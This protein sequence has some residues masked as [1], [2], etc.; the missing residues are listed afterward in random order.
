MILTTPAAQR[1]QWEA[2]REAVADEYF[3]G[4]AAAA[5]RVMDALPYSDIPG[6][7]DVR[8]VMDALP[9]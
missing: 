2:D 8:A 6:W 5:D 9:R 4:D 3:G 1:A 7:H